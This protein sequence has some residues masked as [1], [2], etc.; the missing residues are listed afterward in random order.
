MPCQAQRC[1]SRSVPTPSLR[2]PSAL[3]FPGY[4]P[5]SH[6]SHADISGSLLPTFSLDLLLV[7]L[8]L[9]VEASTSSGSPLLSLPHEDDVE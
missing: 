3:N 2:L 7:M 9:R 4:P 8:L 1:L 5:C 6:E